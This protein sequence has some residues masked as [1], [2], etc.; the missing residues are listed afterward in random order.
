MHITTRISYWPFN[1]AI[2]PPTRKQVCPITLL[3]SLIVLTPLT[4][5]TYQDN[6]V[7]DN[8]LSITP[9]GKVQI[10]QQQIFTKHTMFNL[11]FV[12]SMWLSNSYK[13]YS[14]FK[15]NNLFHKYT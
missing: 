7:V 1:S 13:V 6:V 5:G 2:A 11:T 3:T 4:I 9:M 8:T 15:H 14:S 10:S 12:I